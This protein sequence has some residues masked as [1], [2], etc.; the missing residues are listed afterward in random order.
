M[1][2]PSGKSESDLGRFRIEVVPDHTS[3]TLFLP[4]ETTCSD[5]V[6]KYQTLVQHL[7]TGMC[8]VRYLT[9]PGLVCETCA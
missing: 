1:V 9:V 8:L 6:S 4:N 3:A 5:G 7:T 2:S